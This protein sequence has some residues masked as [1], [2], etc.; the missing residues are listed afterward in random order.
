MANEV[1]TGAVMMCSFGSAPSTF[2]VTRPVVA[3]T[4]AGNILDC[5]PG[6]NIPPFGLC[7]SLAN[8]AVAAATAAAG[9]LT[10][11]P[12]TPVTAPWAPGSPITMIENIPALTHTCKCP[13]GYAGVIS[14]VAPGQVIAQPK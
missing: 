3:T 6:T 10:P 14:I 2:T 9:V 7:S 5:I 12:C 4:P 11:M 8:P 13:C 1:V